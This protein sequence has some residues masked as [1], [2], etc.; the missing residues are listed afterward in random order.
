MKTELT[1]YEIL[2][3]TNRCGGGER[4]PADLDEVVLG[5]V[6]GQDVLEEDLLKSIQSDPSVWDLNYLN[7]SVLRGS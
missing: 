5:D 3:V 1:L 7:T 2:K 6:R 4:D